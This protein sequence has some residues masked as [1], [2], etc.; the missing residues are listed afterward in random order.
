MQIQT[1]N[2]MQAIVYIC[3]YS[4]DMVT[5]EIKGWFLTE[6]VCKA[7][8][9]AWLAHRL[10]FSAKDGGGSRPEGF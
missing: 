9:F 3:V 2:N 4:H 6:D 5:S 8:L 1:V 7:I 10:S